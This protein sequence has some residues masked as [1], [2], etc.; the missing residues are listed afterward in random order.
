MEL[1]DGVENAFQFKMVVAECYFVIRKPWQFSVE[2]FE[3]LNSRLF[4]YSDF[5]KGTPVAFNIKGIIK[6]AQI[7]DDCTVSVDTLVEF[8][9]QI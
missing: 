2:I 1:S 5:L 8:L 4:H 6:E 9:V 7:K 3:K